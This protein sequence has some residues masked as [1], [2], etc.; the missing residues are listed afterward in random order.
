MAAKILQINLNHARAAQDL[1]IQRAIED[2]ISV[3]LIAE[4]YKV[5]PQDSWFSDADNL[6]AVYVNTMYCAESA[7]FVDRG[8]GYIAIKI[9]T[10]NLYSC[11]IP[12]NKPIEEFEIYLQNLSNSMDQHGQTYT[13]LAG[14]RN[15]KHG[16]W[17][18][19]SE[20]ARG[21]ILAPNTT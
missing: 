2:Q 15:A 19:R 17:G 8:P 6:S 12:P 20:D 7:N 11:Y 10:Y 21:R 16:L 1:A 14:D 3:L 5:L 13:I 9:G 4:P 18:A